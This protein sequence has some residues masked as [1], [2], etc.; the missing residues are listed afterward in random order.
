MSKKAK[1]NWLHLALWKQKSLVKFLIYE[2]ISQ[3]SK[4]SV[5]KE[6]ELL[7]LLGI[8]SENK[9]EVVKGWTQNHTGQMC[10]QKQVDDQGLE[11][12]ENDSSCLVF[13][14]VSVWNMIDF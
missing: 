4:G 11:D 14:W 1:G 6:A 10:R 9:Q 7:E 13:L 2:N 3:K 12:G 5:G 8:T